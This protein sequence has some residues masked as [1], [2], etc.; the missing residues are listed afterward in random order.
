M[1]LDIKQINFGETILSLQQKRKVL[2]EE[3]ASIDQQVEVIDQTIESLIFLGNPESKMPLPHNMSEMGLQD[4]VRSIFRRSSP[5]Y[6]LPTDVRDTLVSAGTFGPS[7][8]NLLI[9]IHT[10]ISRM[11]DELEEE[12]RPGGKTAYR[13]KVAKKKA[14]KFGSSPVTEEI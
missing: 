13:W 4:A 5:I 6:L 3:R 11:K 1:S 14:G 2:L 9:S 10:A 8:K 7:S 12:A